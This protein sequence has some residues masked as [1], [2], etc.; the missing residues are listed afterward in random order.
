MFQN[1]LEL[2]QSSFSDSGAIYLPGLI[3]SLLL[4]FSV[5][6]FV[7]YVYR[8]TFNGVLYSRNFNISLVLLTMVATLILKSISSNLAVS[9]GMV[10]A[11]SIVRFRTAIKDPLDTAFM[12]WAVGIG[13]TI[14][15]GFYALAIVGSAI[16]GIFLYVMSNMQM[17]KL[18]SYLL[19]VR[20]DFDSANEVNHMIS[21]LPKVTL[22]AY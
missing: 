14:G 21:G 7:F 15:S 13:I 10:G 8:R 19:V 18:V 12:F 17:K 6:L 2:I 22:I 5:G 4:A 11:L 20:H 9:L 1:I 16:I 3:L